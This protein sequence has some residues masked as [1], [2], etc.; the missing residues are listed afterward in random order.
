MIIYWKLFCQSNQ[1]TIGKSPSRP[2][3][4]KNL[5][6]ISTDIYQK[7]YISLRCIMSQNR[8]KKQLISFH[9]FSQISVL[10]FFKNHEITAI[11]MS[12]LANNSFRADM[13]F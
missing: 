10:L 1:I 12:H 7:N 5:V 8:S 11:V 3:V 6:A 9:W 4:S 2:S 13:E